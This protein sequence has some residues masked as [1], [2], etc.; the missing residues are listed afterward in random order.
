MS[1]PALKAQI[2]RLLAEAP[3]LTDASGKPDETQSAAVQ[4]AVVLKNGPM[5][6]GALSLVYMEIG[7][8]PMGGPALWDTLGRMLQLTPSP[9]GGAPQAVEMFF[10][11]ED[12]VFVAVERDVKTS[13]P[14][15][16]SA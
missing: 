7:P 11:L 16:F 2:I 9:K 5:L 3:K 12:V 15:L 4:C 8:H 14:T 6:Q 1:G 13:G 10:E